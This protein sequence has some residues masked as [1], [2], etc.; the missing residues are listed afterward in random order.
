MNKIFSYYDKDVKETLHDHIEA[1]LDAVSRVDK[2]PIF[3][4][5]QRIYSDI[6]NF[7]D[8][9]R[10]IVVF[11]D[12]GKVF[13]QL[14]PLE[15]KDHLS[16]L[17]HEILSTYVFKKFYDTYY[18]EDS[19]FECKFGL[20]D[21]KIS[22]E[23]TLE[24]S[25]LYHHHAMSL[26]DRLNHF[27]RDVIR[28]E[29]GVSLFGELLIEVGAFLSKKEREVFAITL[30]DLKEQVVEPNFVMEI[31]NYC[32]NNIKSSLWREIWLNKDK[33]VKKFSLVLLSILMVADNMAAQ[34]N[35]KY[36]E[37]IFNE[38]LKEFYNY[39]LCPC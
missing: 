18:K 23:E 33:K 13:Y 31:K 37:G 6:K 1:G 26:L 11:H 19:L 39:Y 9:I 15:N 24:F 32:E 5:I 16:F 28:V 21:H 4:Y 34:K 20:K 12:I 25:I 10:L 30:N 38:V 7:N 2:A 14:N 35:R 29:R 8:L 36:S 27:S 17:G 22:I 3:R